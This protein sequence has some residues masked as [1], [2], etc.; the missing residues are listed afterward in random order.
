MRVTV[1]GDIFAY[2]GN[3]AKMSRLFSGSDS[4]REVFSTLGNGCQPEE[5]GRRVPSTASRTRA[6]HSGSSG[7]TTTTRNLNCLP[8][9][10]TPSESVPLKEIDVTFCVEM[11]R[12]NPSSVTAGVPAEREASCP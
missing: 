4:T 5:E 2:F 1:Q 6:A 7:D 9:I 11:G 3:P 10:P 12:G 8:S